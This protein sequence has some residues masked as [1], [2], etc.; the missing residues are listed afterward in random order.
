MYIVGFSGP[1]YSGKDSIATAVEE[2][3]E[4]TYEFDG[5]V[6]SLAYPMRELGM[7]LLGLNP[8]DNRAYA[9]AKITGHKLFERNFGDGVCQWDTLRQFMISFAEEWVR[10]RYGR[11]FWARKLKQ[12]AGII[13]NDNCVILIPDVG[14]PAEVEYFE[15]EVGAPNVL[16]VRLERD[17]CNFKI[18][19]RDYV[20]GTNVCVVV[21]N[22]TIEWAAQQIVAAMVNIGWKLDK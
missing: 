16:I 22:A 20:V 4:R 18:D 21:N 11:D 10:P 3:L 6:I 12:D 13:W 1:P 17:D 7:Q 15:S 8:G 2:I 14:F 9:D 19:S 5:Y